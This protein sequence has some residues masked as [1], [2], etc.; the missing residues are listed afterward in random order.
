[1]RVENILVVDDKA[2]MRQYLSDALTRQQRTVTTASSAEEAMELVQGGSYD[3]VITDVRMPGA[4]GLTLLQHV[5][6]TSPGTLTVALTAYATVEDAVAAVKAGAADYLSKPVSPQLL[7][8]LL[9]KLE[10]RAALVDENQYLRGELDMK[11]GVGCLVGRSPAICEIRKLVRRAAP[12]DTTVLVTGESGT[13]KELVAR[14]LHAHSRRAAGPFIRVNS[15]ALP[16][17]LLES[18]LFGHEKGAFTGASARR[19]GRF[20]LAD[21][22]TLFLDEISETSMALQAKLL[23][24][25]QEREFERVGGTNTVSVDV[26]VI[27]STNRD[28]RAAAEEDKFRK[29][30]FYRLNVVEIHLPPLRERQGDVLM[31]AKI[32][33]QRISHES[34]REGLGLS[35]EA[36]ACLLAHEWPGNVRELENAVQR[37]AVLSP[38]SVLM[39]SHLGLPPGNPRTDRGPGCGSVDDDSGQGL[40]GKAIRK[41]APLREIEKRAVLE[42]LAFTGGNRKMASQLLGISER[43]IYKKLERYRNGEACTSFRDE[44]END[45]QLAGDTPDLLVTE[46]RGP[47]E[48]R[49][50]AKAG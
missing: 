7:E 30:L 9:K 22:G 21:G 36:E 43:T 45:A 47:R 1:M 27:A 10:E 35:K 50:E 25:L 6:R 2:V 15:P 48:T 37:A 40:A 46:V 8:I 29:D 38:E 13:G 11:G 28:L 3:L 32:F 14:A 34:G 17:T 31:L 4:D 20:E 26:R 19:R 44:H 33:L 16:D 49:N 24:T 23:R 41:I 5:A 39:P 18:E 42:A 12:T